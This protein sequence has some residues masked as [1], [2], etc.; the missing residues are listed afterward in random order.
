[1][2]FQSSF[3]NALS[4]FAGAALGKKHVEGQKESLAEQKMQGQFNVEREINRD[5][6]QQEVKDYNAQH[7]TAY[8]DMN[9]IM[10]SRAGQAL[11]SETNSKGNTSRAVNLPK[12]KEWLRQYMEF[13]GVGAKEAITAFKKQHTAVRKI[14]PEERENFRGGNK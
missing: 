4:I 2:G 13:Y 14:T 6:E 5:Q 7:G 1:M 8:N 3:N 11:A 12:H 9:E 10:A